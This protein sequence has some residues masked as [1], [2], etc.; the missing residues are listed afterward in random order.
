MLKA[1]MLEVKENHSAGQKKL[2]SCIKYFSIEMKSEILVISYFHMHNPYVRNLERKQQLMQ[3]A[4]YY[5]N[6]EI[7][8]NAKQY[9]KL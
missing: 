9:W 2:Q 6:N 8:T 1:E 5:T 7:K 3:N 4:M